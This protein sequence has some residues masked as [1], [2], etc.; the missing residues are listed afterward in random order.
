MPIGVM[1]AHALNDDGCQLASMAA[2]DG[3]SS[4]SIVATAT[5]SGL[6]LGL[7]LHILLS[8]QDDCT[9]VCLDIIGT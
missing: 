6:W 4:L 8:M 1:R 7:V 3:A 9:C 5:T 2:K